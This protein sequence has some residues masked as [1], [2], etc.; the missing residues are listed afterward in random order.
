MLGDLGLLFHQLTYEETAHRSQAISILRQFQDGQ[1]QALTAKRVLDEGVKHPS[2]SE[3]VHFGQ[4]NR[5]AAMGSKAGTVATQMRAKLAKLT[6][7]FT[8]SSSSLRV[9]ATMMK[10][11]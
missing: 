2:S 3:G 4:H 9:L 7:R 10:E 6:A 8:T 1:L 5:R 11:V